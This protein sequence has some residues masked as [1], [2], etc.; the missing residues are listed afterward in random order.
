MNWGNGPVRDVCP[1]ILA[2]KGSSL[3]VEMFEGV[4]VALATPFSGGE[5]D[6]GALRRLVNHVLDHG[7][8]GIVATGTTGETPT[9]TLAERE[10][11]WSLALEVAG[12]NAFVIAGT[13]TN[14][15]RESI[16]FTRRAASIGVDGCMLVTPY[17]NKPGQKGLTAHF[18]AVADAVDIPIV[19]YNVPGRT[20]VNLLPETVVSMA[21]HDRIVAIKEASGSLEQTTEILRKTEITVL[22]GDDALTLPMVAAGARGVV[23]VAGHLVGGEMASMIDH[24]RSGRIEEAAIIHQR[25]SPLFKAL[26]LESNPGPIKAALSHLGMIRNELRL[27]LIPVETETM[28]RVVGEMERLGLVPAGAVR[29]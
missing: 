14:S 15:T 21:G 27:P 6:E 17:Y 7:V 29:S 16:E 23:S 28:S 4:S 11:I 26:F 24:Y 3:E 10:R 19:L 20:G 1:E 25:L 22:S 5:L 9:L 12:G 18:L 13:G 2:L 8:A